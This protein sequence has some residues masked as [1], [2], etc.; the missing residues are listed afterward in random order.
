MVDTIVLFMAVVNVGKFSFL[1]VNPYFNQLFFVESPA[2][3][4]R[5]YYLQQNNF[6]I[7]LWL[8]TIREIQHRMNQTWSCFCALWVIFAT[9][10]RWGNS[11]KVYHKGTSPLGVLQGWRNGH[12]CVNTR[13]C[14]LSVSYTHLTLPTKA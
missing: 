3:S 14:L 13:Y 5:L 1:A 12:V 9:F 8:S 6:L 11:H 7:K 2:F 4:R 10:S